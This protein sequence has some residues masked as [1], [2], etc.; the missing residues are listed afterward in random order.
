M[1]KRPEDTFTSSSKDVP[2]LSVC[3]VVTKGVLSEF[4]L[5]KTSI[6]IFHNCMWFVITDRECAEVLR[7]IRNVNIV[8]ITKIDDETASHGVDDTGLKHNFFDLVM[9]KFA[10]TKA[11]ISESGYGLFLDSDMLFVN[12]IDEHVLRCLINRDIEVILSPHYTNDKVNENRVGNFNAGMFAASNMDFILKWEEYC[13]VHREKSL[14]FEQ[15]P[16]EYIYKI[17]RTM[18]LPINYNIGWW[19]FKPNFSS[20]RFKYLRLDDKGQ[21][22]FYGLCAVNF[23]IHTLKKLRYTN[24]GENLMSEVFRLMKLSARP[25]YKKILMRYEELQAPNA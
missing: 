16:M 6:E 7:G 20:H 1:H 13:I 3:S 5:L 25:E 23:H 14:Y 8:S 15:Q 9:E 19:R 12:R 22:E 2:P 4:L 24:N 17:F 18:S 10:V 11:A 21:I